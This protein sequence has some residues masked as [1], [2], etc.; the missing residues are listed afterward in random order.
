MPRKQAK[1][2]ALAGSPAAAR[3]ATGVMIDRLPFRVN[4]PNGLNG[5]ANR[6]VIAHG[7]LDPS[8]FILRAHA[9][10]VPGAE[11]LVSVSPDFSLVDGVS[12][13]V[14]TQALPAT[15]RYQRLSRASFPI[16]VPPR[17]LALVL[18][19]ISMILSLCIV[20]LRP[21]KKYRVSLQV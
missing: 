19:N 16:R 12:F 20:F 3:L 15:L 5:L 13:Q 8:L 4:F 10:R 21:T 17:S 6:R 18:R 11:Q 9:R 14:F 1:G 2:V 7:L